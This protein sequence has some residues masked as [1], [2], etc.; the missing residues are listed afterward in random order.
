MHS[1]SIIVLSTALNHGQLGPLVLCQLGT[2]KLSAILMQPQPYLKLIL[3]SVINV[4][5]IYLSCIMFF[6]R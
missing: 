6:M 5:I 2:H 4:C 1:L 3:T